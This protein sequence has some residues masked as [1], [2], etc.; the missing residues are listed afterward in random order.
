MPYVTPGRQ[1]SAVRVVHGT[2]SGLSAAPVLTI[3]NF[4]GVHPGHRALIDLTRE[5]A[6]ERSAPVAVLTFDPAPRDVLRPDNPI[7][8]IQSL[9]QRLAHLAGAGVD[10]TVVEPFTLELAALSPAEFAS[11]ILVERLRVRGM[12]LGHDF[13]FGHK[14]AGT[15]DT[16][17][18]LVQVPIRQVEP[19]LLDGR[20]LS[21]SRIREA[22]GAGDVAEAARLLG[23]PHEVE[24]PVVHGDARGRQLGFPTANVVPE[25]GLVPP[26]GVYAV[27][28]ELDGVE[29]PAV[30]NLGTRPTFDGHRLALEVHVLDWTG[31]LYGRSLRVGFVAR[32]RDERRFDGVDALRAAIAADVAEARRALT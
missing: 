17:R 18:E 32:L 5:L 2:R 16:L 29:R 13:R 28:V 21:S 11:R 15:V 14:R 20:P 24:G 19:L 3:G 25:H 27:R 10:I 31:D 30:A 12:A 7:P 26:G 8:R 23:R 22:L 6:A 9:D 1:E 4:D